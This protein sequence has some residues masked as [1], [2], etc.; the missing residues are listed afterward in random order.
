M[1]LIIQTFTKIILIIV[2]I[3]SFLI[4]PHFLKNTFAA[5]VDAQWAKSTVVAPGNSYFLGV[6]ND[7]SGNSYA[8]GYMDGSQYDFGNGVTVTGATSSN[9]LI[10]KYNSSGV[11]QWAK[12]TVSGP[13]SQFN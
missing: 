12:S 2:L 3:L 1:K 5:D 13:A 11:A 7:T 10:V 9:A 6:T 8:V 4:N